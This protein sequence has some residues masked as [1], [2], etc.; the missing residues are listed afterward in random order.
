MSNPLEKITSKILF[1][2]SINAIFIEDKNGKIL[3]VNLA[4][5]KIFGYTKKE[6]L[7][8]T[9]YDV[10][11]DIYVNKVKTNL[12]KGNSYTISGKNKRKDG[13]EFPC[14]IT[15][16]KVNDIIIVIVNDL[17]ETKLIKRK[18]KK[19]KDIARKYLNIVGVIIIVFDKNC[20]VTLINNKGCEILGYPRN[21]ILGKNW[22]N[23]IVQEE[24]NLIKKV[25]ESLRVGDVNP[26][27]YFEYS[28]VRKNGD[29]KLILWHNTVL[30]DENNN[31]IGFLSS[32]EDITKTR[33][34][35]EQLRQSAK[36]EAIGML[37]GGIA[38]DFN[39]ILTVIN[40]YTQN[41]SEKINNS[42]FD[43]KEIS[44]NIKE[45]INAGIKAETL[46][47][48]LLAFSSR[49]I[50]K[51]EVI[52]LNSL[53]HNLQ[54]MLKRLIRED[55]HLDLTLDKNIWNIEVDPGQIEQ[56][57][58]N[59]VINGR[60]AMPKGG[61]LTIKT[62]NIVLNE[63][64]IK[65]NENIF[66]KKD[67]YV[68]L[69]ISDNGVGMSRETQKHIFEPFFTT[70]KDQGTGLGLSTV[71]GIVKQCNG[72]IK[73]SSELNKGTTFK[74]YFPHTIT[75]TSKQFYSKINEKSFKGNK[76]ILVVEDRYEVREFINK[77]LTDKGYNILCAEDGKDA[78][79]KI[80]KY[81]GEVDLLLTD[82]VMPHMSGKT[83]SEKIKKQYPE[84]KIIFMSGYTDDAIV[85]HGVLEDGANFL[86]KPF[87]ISNLL[88]KIK[89]VL[90][91]QY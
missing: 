52:N 60:D 21:K 6:F 77:M 68:L 78:L 59:L 46:I 41:I 27:E 10:A 71:Y 70:K 24:I 83:L 72:A 18:V 8:M 19:E 48:Q 4:A 76:T 35:E 61:I 47:K 14:E 51:L 54:K 66:L 36:M 7:E 89:E 20:N 31:L 57:I 2:I 87:T 56:V 90:S 13:E 55:I 32:G 82:V 16:H 33:D 39:N 30:C 45:V 12:E 28:I 85:Y 40:G 44:K 67:S 86:Q 75:K 43:Y 29:R 84:I 17:S 73:V 34:L 5:E 38:H 15:A 49:Q 37:A 23:F 22:F 81:K 58:M 42:D 91:V 26:V 79:E 53:I 65:K 88:Q 25:F 11:P 63:D 50:M 1:D 74:L 3:D 69:T 80:S 64:Y 9:A 62:K